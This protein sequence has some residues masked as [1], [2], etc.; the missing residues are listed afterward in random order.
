MLLRTL[1]TTTLLLLAGCDIP[2]LGP[3][4]RI[5][6]READAKAI[7]S[8]CRYGLRGIEDCYS[9]NETDSKSDIF[10]GWKDM[11]LYMRENKIDGVAAPK[12]APIEEIIEPAKPKAD[13]KEKPVTNKPTA[14]DK[15]S[16]KA[17]AS[18]PTKANAPASAAA[19]S[20]PAKATAT[21][22]TAATAPAKAPAK[23]PAKE[24][25]AAY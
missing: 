12:T 3:D 19:A 8:A 7:G 22:A 25:P 5:A 10:T 15:P 4:P 2:G 9:Q 6:K 11:D 23:T 24:A 13:T 18:A 20:T 1:L 21:T 17:A 16:A 14:T